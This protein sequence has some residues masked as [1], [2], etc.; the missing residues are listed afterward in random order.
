VI[1]GR[2]DEFEEFWAAQGPKG[3]RAHVQA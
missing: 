3:A 2:L 1:D